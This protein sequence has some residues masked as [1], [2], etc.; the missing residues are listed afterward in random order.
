MHRL[1]DG[2]QR[3]SCQHA[4]RPSE[5]ERLEARRPRRLG[6]ERKELEEQL[7]RERLAK[8][9]R[10]RDRRQHKEPEPDVTAAEAAAA[11][12][13][14]TERL[15][16]ELRARKEEHNPEDLLER[17]G[18]MLFDVAV[19]ESAR[20][21]LLGDLQRLLLGG[22]GS[23]L[24]TAANGN[25]R[26]AC[27]H[28]RAEH[29]DCPRLYSDPGAA[30]GWDSYRKQYFFGHH[31][32]TYGVSSQ[33]HDLPLSL[34]Q[35]PASDTDH[36]G[37][38]YALERLRNRIAQHELP[39]KVWAV[40]HDCGVD[41]EPFYEYL[42][43]EGIRP[44]IPLRVDAPATHPERPELRLSWRGVPLCPGGEEL[45]AWGAVGLER[46]SFVCPVQ[47]H[48]LSR[49]PLAPEDEPAWRCEPQG[50]WTPTVAVSVK[51]N[52]R[53]CPPIA[54]NSAQYE[55]LMKQRSGCERRNSLDKVRF[56][57]EAAHHRRPSFWLIRRHLIA[58]LEHALAWVS[59]LDSTELVDELLGRRLPKAV[60]A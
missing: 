27:E 25:G 12:S 22:D 50:R 54:R 13:K 47:A 52:P 15:V 44:V 19:V 46:T 57:L 60:N 11:G 35:G 59:G 1:Q 28:E 10:R 45:A 48:R 20:R 24:P 40:I 31:S 23:A 49:C 43:S 17:L 37:A 56:D 4:P 42:C 26:R 41:A 32:Y 34:Y 7:S 16:A 5:L 18:S 36:R 6:Q 53:L 55:R 8:A 38:L 14:L 51:D 21:G 29:C 3:G 39:W 58:L 2:P 33:G 30:W 9:R